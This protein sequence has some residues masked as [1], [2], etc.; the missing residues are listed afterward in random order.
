MNTPSVSLQRVTELLAHWSQRGTMP[1]SASEE[2][3]DDFITK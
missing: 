3:N 1:C 2:A